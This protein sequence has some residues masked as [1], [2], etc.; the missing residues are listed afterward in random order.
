MFIVAHVAAVKL[1]PRRRAGLDE[2]TASRMSNV[3][4]IM[5]PTS[6]AAPPIDDTT[7]IVMYRK[8]GI[9]LMLIG[10]PKM[11]AKFCGVDK[12]C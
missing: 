5:D 3:P 1:S 12:D 8:V 7:K 4:L 11:D 6:I 10:R 2:F 9:D